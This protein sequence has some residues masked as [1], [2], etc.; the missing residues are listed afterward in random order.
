MS[1]SRSDTDDVKRMLDPENIVDVGCR[2]LKHPDCCVLCA[3]NNDCTRV[4]LHFNCFPAGTVVSGPSAVAS[5]VRWYCG[6]LVEFETRA[7]AVVAATPNHPVLAAQ[8]WVGA[9]FLNE[10]DY[11]V[12]E[13]RA[14]GLVAGYPGEYQQPALIE[15]VASSVGES[16]SVGAVRVPVTALDLHGDGVG[17]DVAVIRADGLLEHHVAQAARVQQRGE[18]HLGLVHVREVALAGFGSPDPRFEGID[19]TSAGA[20]R[21]GSVSD[22]LFGSATRRHE[23]VGGSETSVVGETSDVV[24]DALP[25]DAVVLREGLDGLAGAVALDQIIKVRRFPFHGHVYNLETR[26]GWYLAD[27]IVVHNCRCKTEGFLKIAE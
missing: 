11:V 26:L 14:E 4:P 7:G 17:S 9:G 3:A 12:R 16:V 10:G 24:G 22:S 25:G 6:E 18:S 20:I 2:V 13:S 15:D 1:V 8:G 19:L 23:P 21:G 5:I 27:S